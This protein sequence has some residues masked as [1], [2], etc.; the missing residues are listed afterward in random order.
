MQSNGHVSSSEMVGMPLE[1][2]AGQEAQ[3]PEVDLAQWGRGKGEDANA[4][5]DAVQRVID[6]YILREI[7]A[8]MKTRFVMVVEPADALRFLVEEGIIEEH[9]ARRDLDDEEA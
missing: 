8:W 2:P 7:D 4:P 6:D 5:F 9:E 3:A 1:P